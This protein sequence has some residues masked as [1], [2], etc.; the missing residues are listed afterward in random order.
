MRS[1]SLSSLTTPKIGR[2]LQGILQLNNQH[3]NI[4]SLYCKQHSTE[5]TSAGQRPTQNINTID[6]FA[7]NIPFCLPHRDNFRN[8]WHQSS[9]L[10]IWS[11]TK[12]MKL[13][14]LTDVTTFTRPQL[15][16][17]NALHGLGG[18]AKNFES[19]SSWDRTPQKYVRWDDID[20]EPTVLRTSHTEKCL[21]ISI[22]T[23]K[24]E[25]RH[26]ALLKSPTLAHWTARPDQWRLQW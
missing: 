6:I 22:R 8:L 3:S 12:I 21:R 19:M 23:S 16:M 18:K 14:P 5:N 4:R 1:L 20:D 24:T 13:D 2:Y 17:Q 11:C 10:F 9:T 26:E 25:S 15:S 7:R